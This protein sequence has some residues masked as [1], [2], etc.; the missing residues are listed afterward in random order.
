MITKHKAFLNWNISNSKYCTQNDF[1]LK[2]VTLS[3]YWI[4]Q[5]E[6]MIRILYATLFVFQKT[7][8]IIIQRKAFLKGNLSN[9]RY[10]TN[11]VLF[12]KTKIIITRKKTFLWKKYLN[13]I[14]FIQGHDARFKT[15]AGH[16]LRVSPRAFK[17]DARL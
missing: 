11:S 13:H 15:C 12:Q 6:V 14:G 7:N 1:C 16:A 8:V 10:Y 3:L 5:I 4:F 9:Y 2:R 17:S